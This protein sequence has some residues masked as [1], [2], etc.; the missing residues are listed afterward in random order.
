VRPR[1]C[2]ILM[3]VAG[4]W[5]LA[6]M[7]GAFHAALLTNW[8]YRK[9]VGAGVLPLVAGFKADRYQF[10]LVPLYAHIQPRPQFQ[11][12]DRYRAKVGMYHFASA[13]PVNCS[14][15]LLLMISYYFG[16]VTSLS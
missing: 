13:K 5:L 12:R 10:Q 6:V 3:D 11:R 2:P 14:D 4:M 8:K 9:A 7:P 16:M 15:I 1:R